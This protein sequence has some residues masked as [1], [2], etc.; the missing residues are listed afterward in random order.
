MPKKKKYVKAKFI[1]KK[2]LKRSLKKKE[3]LHCLIS[4]VRIEE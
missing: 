2:I 4:K 1:E 3:N